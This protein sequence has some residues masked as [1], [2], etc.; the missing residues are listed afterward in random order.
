MITIDCKL[1]FLFRNDF[2]VTYDNDSNNN[3]DDFNDNDDYLLSA[4]ASVCE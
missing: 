4:E 2:D 1:N 3:D